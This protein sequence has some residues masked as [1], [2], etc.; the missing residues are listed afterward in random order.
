[1]HRGKVLVI[2]HDE[3]IRRSLAKRLSDTGHDVALADSGEAGLTAALTQCPDVIVLSV[4]TDGI[5]TC[6]D[7]RKHLFVPVILMGGGSDE[8]DIELA[9]EAGGDTYLARPVKAAE[10]VAYVDA[11]VRRETVYSRRGAQSKLVKVKDLV[12]NLSAHELKRD[13]AMIPL[14]P[15][16]FKL[17]RTLAEN[18][19]RVLTR[20]QLLHYV[21]DFNAKGLYSRTVDVHIGRVRGKIGDD[22]A[23]PHYIVT[24]PGLG[25][26]MPSR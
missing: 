21:W 15:T 14:T 12:L 2:D 1:M 24:V 26:K 9:L 23:D 25:Y 22:R 17:I 13:G 11:A 18:V 3:T 5:Q 7:I 20:E 19:D 6:R 8:T 10:L 4:D 16:E